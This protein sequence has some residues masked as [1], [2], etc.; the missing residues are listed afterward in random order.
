VELSEKSLEVSFDYQAVSIRL[1][2]VAAVEKK[3]TG[4]ILAAKVVLM[5]YDFET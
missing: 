3:K 1:L 4:E 5:K 2:T